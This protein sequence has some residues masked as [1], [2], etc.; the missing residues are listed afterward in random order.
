MLREQDLQRRAARRAAWMAPGPVS[1]PA[2]PI[3]VVR[4]GLPGSGSSRR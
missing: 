1:K 4:A 3:T 2:P